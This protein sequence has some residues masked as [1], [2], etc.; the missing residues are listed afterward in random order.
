MRIIRATRRLEV[1][2]WTEHL[3]GVAWMDLLLQ[4]APRDQDRRHRDVDVGH[5]TPGSRSHW[6]RHS[7][8]QLLIRLRRG[9]GRRP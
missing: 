7:A 9:L 5:F 6:H 8:G 1:G 2:A 3:T 4:E